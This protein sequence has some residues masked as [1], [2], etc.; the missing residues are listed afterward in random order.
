MAKLIANANYT[1]VE[2]DKTQKG[3][4]LFDAED[5]SAP[6]E[7]TIWNET[8]KVTKHPEGKPWIRCPK[9]VEVCNRQYFSEDLFIEETTKA[10]TTELK[11]ERKTAAARVLGASGVNQKVVKNLDEADA[12]RYT[13]ICTNGIKAYK[14]AKGTSKKIKPEDMTKEQLEE[15]IAALREGRKVTTTTGPKSWLDML[16]AETHDEYQALLTKAAENKEANKGSR[17]GIKLSDEEKAARKAKRDAK[18]LS[19]AEKL[20]AALTGGTPVAPAPIAED[21]VEEDEEIDDEDFDDVEEDD[22]D[23][24]EQ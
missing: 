3:K 14:D 21:D 24:D 13:E 20:L 23:S 4:Y 19:N 6:V 16:D 5:G 10:N 11:V 2:G 1:P 17:K 18:E 9:M 15:Y 22:I 8:S 7:C 12:A